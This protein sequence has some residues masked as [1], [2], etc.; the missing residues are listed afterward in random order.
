MRLE[1]YVFAVQANARRSIRIPK[2]PEYPNQV[3]ANAIGFGNLFP[4]FV[5]SSLTNILGLS[6]AYGL[7]ADTYVHAKS[8]HE[9][10]SPFF[11]V[12]RLYPVFL[13][14]P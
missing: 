2:L 5:K 8:T 4:Y 1:M 7:H 11:S 6:L 9:Q 3:P 13:E 14:A 10:I 12:E